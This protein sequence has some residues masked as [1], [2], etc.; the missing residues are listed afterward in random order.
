MKKIE[1]QMLL[2]IIKQNNSLKFNE[3]CN[4]HL[5]SYCFTK[6]CV[7]LMA[8][9]WNQKDQGSIPFTNIYYVDYVSQP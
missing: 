7:C 3:T 1:S 4:M 5:V 9:I 6:W 2:N 8:K